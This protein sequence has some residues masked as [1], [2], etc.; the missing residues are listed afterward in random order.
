M[1]SFVSIQYV[2]NV[3]R[4]IFAMSVLRGILWYVLTGH[5]DTVVCIYLR[6]IGVLWY[7]LTGH[8]GTVV[9]TYGASGYC[10][11]SV[12]LGSGRPEKSQ[13]ADCRN[14][15]APAEGRAKARNT[16]REGGREGGRDT[17]H[18]HTHTQKTYKIA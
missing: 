12:E 15:S 16:A 11:I 6:G 13:R 14:G 9:C 7:V 17:T 8:R 1:S 5:R 10:G 18:T 4:I 3:L 2:H